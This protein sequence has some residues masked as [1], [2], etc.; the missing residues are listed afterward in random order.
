[1]LDAF[2]SADQVLLSGVQGI[3]D[4]ITTPGPDQP[5]LRRRQVGHAGRRLGAHGDRLGP[6][7]GP[8]GAGRRAGDLLA[9]CS[10]PASTARTACC[11]RSRV[12]R[13]LGLFE[14]NEA[15]R[16]VQE[17][18]HPEANIIFGAVIDDALGDE[19]RV[20]VI[21]AGFDSGTPTRRGGRARPR[22]I[23]GRRRRPAASGCRRRHPALS[24]AAAPAAPVAGRP[25]P[26]RAGP[27]SRLAAPAA[28][29]RRR[30]RRVVTEPGSAQPEPV[31]PRRP[32]A[33]GDLR[34]AATTSTCPTS[35]S[36]PR[37][38]DQRAGGGWTWC[39]PARRVYGGVVFS[40]AGPAGVTVAVTDR[41]AG[42]AG[43][44]MRAQP[45]RGTS[46][47]TRPTSRPTGPA[48]APSCGLAPES[49]VFMDQC[50]GADVGR[51][52]RSVLRCRPRST[53]W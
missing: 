48:R 36:S 14:I 25:A 24:P 16:L 31:P 44:G 21:A 22:Q 51:R 15:A 5:R 52:R 8:R 18:A 33:D 43:A 37:S 10:R 23:S 34:R 46:A 19:V 47:T 2:R 26:S 13:D 45:R 32:P 38:G 49:L 27:G 20:T 7:R 30:R 39:P 4:L 42:S 29:R 40:G 41:P 28:R 11:C 35:S 12:A 53:R 3:T 50:H 17:A 1:M 9:R 6:R